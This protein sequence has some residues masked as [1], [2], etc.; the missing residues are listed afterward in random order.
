MHSPEAET[1]AGKLKGESSNWFDHDANKNY[2]DPKPNVRGSAAAKE[3]LEKSR[4]SHSN[5]YPL[6]KIKGLYELGCCS[7]VAT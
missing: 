3:M 6:M 7:I 1:N 4:G 5:F 2:N